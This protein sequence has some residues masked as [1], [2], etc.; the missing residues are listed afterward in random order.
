MI[1][2]TLRGTPLEVDDLD[3]EWLLDLAREAEVQCRVAER[4]KLR[5]AAHW[6]ALH[7]ATP[8]SGREEWGNTGVLE[9]EE[10]I[11]GE[12]TP[13]VAAF[14]AEPLAA[15]LGVSTASAMNLISAALDLQHRLPRT[16]ARVEALDVPAWKA[17]LVARRTH[18]LSSEAAAH[19][20]AEL[21]PVLATRGA[22]T[23]ERVVA[24]A[25]ARFA[26]DES[27]TA[28]RVAREAWDVT[29]HHPGPGD[30]AGTSWV[31]AVADTLDVTKFGD[32]VADI[33]GRL[34]AAGD[35]DT[36][37][38]RRA[39]ALGLLADVHAGADLD[40]LIAAVTTPGSTAVRRPIGRRSRELQVYVHLE[41]NDL[42]APLNAHD[43][44][45]D[46]RPART[47][48][49]D[50][51]AGGS[52]TVEGLGP[53]TLA[54]IEEWLARHTATGGRVRLTPVVDAVRT[55]AVDRH[56]PP[57]WMAAQ[58]RLRDPQCVFP[59]CPTRSRHCDLDHIDP[60]DDTGPPGQTHPGNLAP[61][62]RRHHRAKTHGR[63]HYRRL[64]D[65][66]YA[67]TSPHHDHY[68]VHDGGTL[69]LTDH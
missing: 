27:A 41:A 21:A 19:V 6:A 1:E 58:V 5:L 38:Q 63:W 39:K 23:I 25:V 50:A 51:D 28:E 20:D 8:A 68:L 46:H 2:V 49:S 30:W 60:Y 69:A 57:P 12:G 62:C 4:R 34:G 9:C 45:S 31:E 52:A 44:P 64:P 53:V 18:A 65:G 29:V 48:P 10:A 13:S 66:T 40:D 67:W 11:G 42:P 43:L 33:A 56:D 35:P 54:R 22:P 24:E 32:V 36:L 26:P 15:A 7:P 55:E 16:W 37:G 14:T 59:G 61:L 17:K 47:S 3:A